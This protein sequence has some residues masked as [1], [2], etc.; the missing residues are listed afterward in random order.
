MTAHA[1]TACPD[2][3]RCVQVAASRMDAAPGCLCEAS[4]LAAHFLRRLGYPTRPCQQACLHDAAEADPLSTSRWR[5]LV[6]ALSVRGDG[7]LPSSG[8]GTCQPATVV[9][10]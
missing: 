2:V 8:C 5:N 10:V 9:A 7:Y 4:L 1:A 6:F 3:A